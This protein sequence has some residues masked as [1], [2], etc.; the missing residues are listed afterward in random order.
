[1][2]KPIA[3]ALLATTLVANAQTILPVKK[4]TIFKNSTA[5]VVKEGNATVKDGTVKLPIPGQTQFGTYFIGAGKD[6]AI[7]NIVFRNDTIKSKA[8]AKEVWQYLAGN[9]N[10]QVTL[11]YTPTQG[12]DKTVTGKVIAY[13]LYSGIVRFT[14][15][16]GRTIVMNA[17][18]IYQADFKEEPSAFYMAD[19]IK[20]MAVLRPEKAA[21]NIALQQVHITGGINWIP[22]YYLRLTS[23]KNARLEMKAVVE[24]FAEDLK[25]AE[26]ELVVGA[27]Q[28]IHSGQL[29]PITYDYIS[30]NGLDNAIAYRAKN[31]MQS[32]AM[33][34]AGAMDESAGYFEGNFST[35]GEKAGDMYIYKLGKITLAEQTKGTFPIFAAGVEYKDKYEGTIA[36]ATNYFNN[37]F[38]PQEEKTYDVFHSLE[39][40]NVS[41]VPLTTASVMVVN[42]KEQFVAQDEIKYTPVGATTNIRLSKAIDV[43]MKNQEEEKTREDNAKKIGKVSYSKVVVKGTVN[44]ENYQGKDATITVTKVLNGTVTSQ[45]NDGK[46]VK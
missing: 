30:T 29:D 9:P 35:D 24:N 27:P 15:D 13:D 28:M 33:T 46:V 7:K 17:N 40:K 14:T 21:D 22:S 20:R 31:Y 12:I 39:V 25:D 8:V 38:V 6:N 26:T 10:K 37:R 41:T 32:N 23:D 4:V 1:M 19:S 18:S 16:A 36:D 34:V 3:L 5:M 42:E 43:I 44:V 11:A 45:S 2:K